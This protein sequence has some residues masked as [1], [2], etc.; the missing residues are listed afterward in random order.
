VPFRRRRDLLHEH[1]PPVTPDE[2]AVAHLKH[3]ESCESEE[4]R[5]A[6]EAFWQKAVAGRSEGLMVKLLDSGEVTEIESPSKNGKTRRKPLPATYE[7]GTTLPGIS[8]FRSKHLTLALYK[9]N[10]LL[11]G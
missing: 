9:T 8:S 2:V 11:H 6:V 7:A 5:A 4:G 1:F 3:V 10:E